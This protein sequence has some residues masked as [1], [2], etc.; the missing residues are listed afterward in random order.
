MNGLK[1]GETVTRKQS[2]FLCTIVTEVG[3]ET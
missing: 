2:V 3:F 1:R